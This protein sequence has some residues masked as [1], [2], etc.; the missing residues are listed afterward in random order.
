MK[1]GIIDCG[2]FDFV[3]DG[4]DYTEDRI[5]KYNRAQDII[6]RLVMGVSILSLVVSVCLYTIVHDIVLGTLTICC[7][8]CVALF[9]MG[10][11]NLIT[12]VHYKLINWVYKYRGNMMNYEVVGNSLVI[13]VYGSKGLIDLINVEEIDNATLFVRE[14]LQLAERPRIDVTQDCI[15]LCI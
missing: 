3:Y 9:F 11:Y 4:D 8:F 14:K 13:R 12:P 15:T 2:K 7:W 5:K 6:R 10:V 1:E